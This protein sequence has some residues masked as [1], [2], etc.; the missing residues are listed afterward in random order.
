[1]ST[2][3]SRHSVFKD[4]IDQ[5]KIKKLTLLRILNLGESVT[6]SVRSNVSD[7]VRGAKGKG[8]TK[9]DALSLQLILLL[10]KNGFDLNSIE[11][12]ESGRIVNYDLVND[13]KSDII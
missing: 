10:E 6:K 2:K 11:F 13:D 1:M 4:T 7:K 5:I 3:D 9:A 8:V 12:D